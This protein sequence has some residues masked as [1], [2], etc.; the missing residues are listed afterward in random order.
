MVVNIKDPAARALELDNSLEEAM[1]LALNKRLKVDGVQALSEEYRQNARDNMGLGDA[2]VRNIGTTAG[3][4]AAGDDSRIVGAL[5]PTTGVFRIATIAAA[6]SATIPTAVNRVLIEDVVAHYVKAVSEPAHS[7]KFQNGSQ[8]WAIDEHAVD[9]KMAGAV[10][11]GVTN[12][13]SAF[14]A[15]NS[16]GKAFIAP[17]GTYELGGTYAAAQSVFLL[18]ATLN[19]TVFGHVV[20]ISGKQWRSRTDRPSG[21]YTGTPT[22][23]EVV[24]TLANKHIVHN[25]AAGYQ[26]NYTSDSGGR[27]SVPAVV[28]QAF[29]SGYGD[30]PSFAARAS[31]TRHANWASATKWT[32]RNS[33]PLYDGEAGASSSHVNLYGSEFHTNDYGHSDVAALGDVRAFIRDGTKTAAYTSPWIGSRMQS[34]GTNAADAGYQVVGKWNVGLDFTGMTLP[35]NNAAIAMPTNARIY[36]GADASVP[37]TTWFAGD[38]GLLFNQ[39][40]IDYNGTSIRVVVGGTA[41]LQ[42]SSTSVTTTGFFASTTGYRTAGFQVVGI[43]KTGW[44]TATGTATRTTFDTT[45]VTLPQLAERVKALIDDFHSASGNHGLLTT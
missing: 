21:D 1:P 5:Q 28:V 36:M 23:Y 35:A 22:A 13:N 34:V 43:R 27:T 41:T 39:H 19:Q 31:I 17:P 8:W 2:S 6:P 14:V 24:Y 16:F 7:L 32:G 15:A 33:I 10:G 37:G 18:G 45:S 20:G 26:E 44:S 38:T 4:A 11:N 3:T 29:H 42:V 9:V 25:N 40:W 30:M 12:D